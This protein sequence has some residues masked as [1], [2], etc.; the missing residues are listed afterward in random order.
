VRVLRFFLPA[1]VFLVIVLGAVAVAS[2][3]GCS[4]TDQAQLVD[5]WKQSHPTTQTV[6]EAGAVVAAG[7]QSAVTG[8]PDPVLNQ[9]LHL[10]G[11]LLGGAAAPTA[12]AVNYRSQVKQLT[13]T[14]KPGGR[15][16]HDPPAPPPQYP[17]LQDPG[18]TR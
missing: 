6:N 15:R 2:A 10:L 9:F 13:A 4:A 14:A 7:V 8:S 11:Y 18:P 16:R 12:V 17:R 1:I 3:P 5:A